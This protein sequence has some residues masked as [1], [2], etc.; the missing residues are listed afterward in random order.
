M[1]PLSKASLVIPCSNGSS[2]PIN[3]FAENPADT[4]A[5]AAASPAIGCRPAPAKT[6][7]PNGITTTYPASDAILDIIPANTTT[8]VKN[9]GLTLL[10]SFFKE[11]LISPDHSAT[12]TP[13]IATR[14]VPKGAK[15]VKF[16]VAELKMY[17]RPSAENRFIAVTVTS[18]PDL[19]SK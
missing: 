11:V 3:R 12:P 18:S 14:T 10:N 9:L 2:V 19:A 4:P 15:P 5:K 7:A 13:S 16:V 8:A 1:P 6:I 17:L